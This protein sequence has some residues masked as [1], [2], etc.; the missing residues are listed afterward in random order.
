[1]DN[2]GED[3]QIYVV[4]SEKSQVFVISTITFVANQ[5]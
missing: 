4:A 2:R 3:L 5:S 1:M